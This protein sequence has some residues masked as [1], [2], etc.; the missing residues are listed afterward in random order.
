MNF[1]VIM[2][3]MTEVLISRLNFGSRI[4]ISL[5]LNELNGVNWKK[6]KLRAPKFF[7]I[8]FK[9]FP[10]STICECAGE[11]EDV[12]RYVLADSVINFT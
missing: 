6:H 2:T 3:L 12:Q 5:N 1:N 11:F 9:I 8:N 7:L 4:G 10:F